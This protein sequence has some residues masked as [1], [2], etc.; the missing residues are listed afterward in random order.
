MRSPHA[1][2]A[3]AA[4]LIIGGVVLMFFGWEGLADTL[5]VP[6]QVAFAVSGGMAGVALMG[7][8]LVVLSV[9]TTRFGT[10]RRS[11]ELRR[12]V[13][14]SVDLLTFVRHRTDDGTSPF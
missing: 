1:A 9:Q 8:G 4:G 10:A 11:Q 2:S 5:F 13:A 12:M 3:V 14:D 7:V 6:T